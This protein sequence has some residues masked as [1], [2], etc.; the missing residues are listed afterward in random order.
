MLKYII[1]RFEGDMAACE[2]A[3]QGI[4]NIARSLLPAD[5]KE[6]DCIVE[7]AEGFAVDA[8]ETAKRKERIA[9]LAKSL[10]AE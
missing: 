4:V 1:D 7:A 5:A 10:F 9:D 3:G 8:D 2:D 6:G